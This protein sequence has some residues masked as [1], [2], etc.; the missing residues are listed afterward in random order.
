MAFEHLNYIFKGVSLFHSKI[1]IV[2]YNWTNTK[3][4]QTLKTI[5]K[6]HLTRIDNGTI[7]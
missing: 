2:N 5:D 3:L 7:D 6:I 4:R 1:K